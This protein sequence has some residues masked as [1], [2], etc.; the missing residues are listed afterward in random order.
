MFIVDLNFA[1][2]IEYCIN[3]LDN[4]CTENQNTDKYM[5]TYRPGCIQEKLDEISS[6]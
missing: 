5:H 6:H 2:T 3:L 1:T 4:I